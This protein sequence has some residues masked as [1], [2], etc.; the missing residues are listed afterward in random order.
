MKDF[1]VLVGTSEDSLTEVLQSALRNDSIPE[2]F[3]LRHVNQAGILFPTRYVQIVPLSAHGQSFHISIW[4]VALSG[5]ADEE[6]VEHIRTRYEEHQED[7]TMKR[8]LKHLRQRRLLTP[9]KFIQDRCK[10]RLE[11]PLVSH[12]FETLVLRGNFAEAEQ[13]MRAC[14]D[15]RLF[16]SFVKASQPRAHWRRINAVD[17]DGD[18]PMKRGG[19]AM[20]VDSEKGLIYL[21]GGWDGTKNL[22]DY[23]VYE[24]ANNRW[25]LVSQHTSQDKNG[26]G[27]RA[28]HKMVFDQKTGCIYLL[29]KLGDEEGSRLLSEN[30]S[31]QNPPAA[32]E[33][34]F[35]SEFYRYRTRGIDHGNWELL[36]FDT[37]A[38]GGPP[39]LFDHQLVIDSES[40]IIYV[41]GGRVVDGEKSPIKYSGFYSYNIPTSKWKNLQPDPATSQT[42]PLRFGHSMLFE[43]FS[44]SIFIFAGQREDKYLADLWI[45]DTQTS[46]ACE[47]WSDFT[48]SGGPEACFTQRSVIN[49]DA[50]EVYMI[51]GLTR[52]RAGSSAKTELRLDIPK[53]VY[54][55]E[56]YP[57]KWMRIL[58]GTSAPED[59]HVEE[60][61]ARYAHQ[62]V[63]DPKT[64]QAFM[65]GG[66]GGVNPETSSRENNQG[67]VE[68]D[69]GTRLD[70]FWS[71]ELE[72]IS[73]EEIIRRTSFKIRTQQ[74]REMCEEQPAVRAL[75]FL[76]TEV[77]SV[78]DH[79]SMDEAALFRSLLTYLL[80]PTARSRPITPGGISRGRDHG[81][82][83]S[84]Q[85]Q[86]GSRKR[87]R[88]EDDWTNRLSG[89]SDEDVDIS[90]GTSEASNW[91]TTLTIGEDPLEQSL[92]AS[93]ISLSAP[94]DTTPTPDHYHSVSGHVS[95]PTETP[96]DPSQPPS[97]TKFKQR[98]EVFESLL[99]FI[100]EDAKE[101]SGNLLDCIN[102]VGGF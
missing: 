54:R 16:D 14:S 2:T 3:S 97:P 30:T 61:Q 78:V 86:E 79:S 43:P 18:F 53:W 67:D 26:P 48:S 42:I 85:H 49:T 57:G 74:F 92:R 65:H 66:N 90:N 15:N 13:C 25:K 36:N 29:G 19:H 71:M 99:E 98:V 63:Y 95:V 59:G 24:I 37:A 91:I 77:S 22:D 69:D 40:Q 9:L 23:W 51:C 6:Y 7:I 52:A 93:L 31:E 8:I 58:P 101:P 46:M 68:G 21:H 33:Q 87:S 70:D 41:F 44:K 27:P 73:P 56:S 84:H 82:G 10:V 81:H 11:H 76:Q 88:S 72:R 12:L 64:G 89:E 38:S 62:L 96:S 83:R 32:G 94:P 100:N 60:P 39:L 5:I 28:C 17:A 50:K 80:N 1:R 4:H 55:Y 47:A 35:C 75:S 45:Y 34:Q 102:V 20:C